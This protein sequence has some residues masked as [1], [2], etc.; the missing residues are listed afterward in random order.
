[1]CKTVNSVAI[2]LSEFILITKFTKNINGKRKLVNIKLDS[3][4][5][6]LTH[7]HSSDFA[8]FMYHYGIV[9]QSI[10]T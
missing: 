5:T 3:K 7:L 4:E 1:M 2:D 9:S 10:Y 6:I 8:S